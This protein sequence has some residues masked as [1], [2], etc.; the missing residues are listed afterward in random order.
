[1][2]RQMHLHKHGGNNGTPGK[3]WKSDGPQKTV[4]GG[5]VRQNEVR[6][7]KNV[8]RHPTSSGEKL[9]LTGSA[10]N[11]IKPRRPQAKQNDDHANQS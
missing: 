1:M 6:G 4:A 8:G 3:H 10:G 7:E 2:F 5:E 9:C 11:N